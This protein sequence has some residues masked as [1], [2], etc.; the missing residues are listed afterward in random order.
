MSDS[1][2]KKTIRFSVK[3]YSIR[4]DSRFLIT[5][6]HDTIVDVFV[7]VSKVFKVQT[8]R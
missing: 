7:R 3:F 8:Y 6:L 2:E 5:T 4:L 1:P